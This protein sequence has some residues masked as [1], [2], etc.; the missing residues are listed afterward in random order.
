LFETSNNMRREEK[1]LRFDVM[2]QCLK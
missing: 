2:E 1:N